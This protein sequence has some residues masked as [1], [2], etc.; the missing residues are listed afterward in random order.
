MHTFRRV[1][2]SRKWAREDRRRRV[3]QRNAGRRPPPHRKAREETKRS[4][5][6][7]SS[8]LRQLNEIVDEARWDWIPPTQDEVV[9]T[10]ETGF[11]VR[12]AELEH[13]IENDLAEML[14][15]EVT[16]SVSLLRGSPVNGVS[17][18][19]DDQLA[20][21]WL[22][23]SGASVTV[24]AKKFLECFSVVSR[25]PL[26]PHE[27]YSA[28]NETPVTV[29]ERVRV[30]VKMPLYE[31]DSYLGMIPVMVTGVVADVGHNILSTEHMVAAGW[32]VK[33]SKQEISLRRLKG[34]LVGYGQS[35]AGCP[36]IY[37]EGTEKPTK[38][39]TFGR[40][41]EK[42]EVDEEGSSSPMEVGKVSAMTVKMKEELEVHRMRGHIPFMSG[43]PQ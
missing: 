17:S 23:D 33:F 3:W 19:S 34:G 18:L 25:T 26:C 4:V 41:Q 2:G 8:V 5:V 32:E 24:I 12:M 29:F 13:R 15:K 16:G 6:G 38:K 36:W 21:W 11:K 42:M 39:V 7:V 37:L 43:C 10:L 30:R 40:T 1:F 14:G 22:V 20:N 27:R 9:M 28:A 35:W 31:G